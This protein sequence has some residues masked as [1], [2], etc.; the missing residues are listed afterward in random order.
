M[1]CPF[2]GHQEDRVLDT[3]VQREGETIRRR[4]E[5]LEC[6]GRFTTVEALLQV[7]PLIIKKDARREP[8]SK[9]KLLKGI[10]AACQKRPVSLAQMEQ[11]VERVSRW[12]LSRSEREVPTPWIGEKVIKE[13]RLLD[14]VAYVRFASVYRDFQDVREFVTAVE[15]DPHASE[16]ETELLK[17]TPPPADV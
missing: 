11:I 12:V 1:K 5:C 16:V 9:E 13:L 7:F 4:R 14:N 17:L 15:S 10:Q 3:R 6:G 2:C 8:F